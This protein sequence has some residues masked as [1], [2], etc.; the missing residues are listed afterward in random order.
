VLWSR[1][2]SENFY[3]LEPWTVLPNS[4]GRPDGELIVLQPGE[5]FRAML[6]MAVNAI[7]PA[8]AFLSDRHS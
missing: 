3:Y 7:W 5:R 1:S 8:H 4:F 2:P 6:T